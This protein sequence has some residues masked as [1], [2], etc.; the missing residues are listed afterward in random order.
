M[1]TERH[2]TTPEPVPTDPAVGAMT[3]TEVLDAARDRGHTTQMIA[4]ES[5]EV[6]CRSCNSLVNP[7]ALS[8]DHVDRLEGASDAADEML[9]ASVQCPRCGAKGVL[10]LGYGPNASDEDI[11]V[12]PHLS[13]SGADASPP[14]APAD[15]H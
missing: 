10:T 15:D 7:A 2:D 3:L 4:R 5:G 13:L 8:V 14:T 12:L 11:A 9:V 1:T 6:T